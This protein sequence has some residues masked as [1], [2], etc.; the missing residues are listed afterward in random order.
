[1][2]GD[3]VTCSVDVCTNAVYSLGWC[4]K[5]H[6]RHQTTRTAQYEARLADVGKRWAQQHGTRS[7]YRK[8]CRCDECRRA[9]TAYRRRYRQARR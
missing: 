8:G 9:E 5:H 7:R 1:M 6:H 4:R 2:G 3:P